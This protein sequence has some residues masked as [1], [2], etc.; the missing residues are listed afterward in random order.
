VPSPDTPDEHLDGSVEEDES[1]SDKPA[2]SVRPKIPEVAKKYKS[3]AFGPRNFLWLRKGELAGTPRPG[4][5]IELEYDLI[6]LKRVGIT[7]LVSLTTKPVDSTVLNKY[8]I[9]GIAFPIKDMGVPTVE[10]AIKLCKQVSQLTEQGEAIAMHCKAGMGR[11]GTMLVAQL[12]WEGESAL[13]ALESARCIEPRWV[14]SEAQVAFLEEFA[15]AVANSNSSKNRC[16][17]SP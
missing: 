8:D 15:L 17:A 10:S 6:A 2:K 12:I 16:L 11:T 9:K 5:L 3:D 1:K 13:D 14:Q 4:L 7:V